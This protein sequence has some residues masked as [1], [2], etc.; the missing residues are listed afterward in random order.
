MTRTTCLVPLGFDCRGSIPLVTRRAYP[1]G[2]ELEG[3][4]MS[5]TMRAFTV[6][7]AA[8]SGLLAAGAPSATLAAGPSGCVSCHLDE[9]M[10]VR[11]LA[12]D[13]GQEVCAA[14]RRRLRRLGGSVGATGEGPGLSASSCP[15]PT[16]CWPA[17]AATAATRPAWTRPPPTRASTRSPPSANPRKACGDCHGEIVATAK[18]SLHATLSTFSQGARE[19]GERGGAGDTSTRRE[20]TTARPAT[21]VAAG[22]T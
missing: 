7:A 18:D 19:A 17:R 1:A 12:G 15:P 16:A 8:L 11:N 10:L 21:R 9:A 6:V 2:S 14:V 20:G 3:G 22:V 4:A 5:R 13:D